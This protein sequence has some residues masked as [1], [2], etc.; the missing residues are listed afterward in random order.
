MIKHPLTVLLVDDN[1]EFI[2][3]MKCLLMELKQIEELKVAMDYEE[4]RKMLTSQTP[5]LV[6]LDIH[7][8]GKN[9]ID[10][11]KYIK[12]LDKPCRV[13]M[14]SNQADEYYRDLCLKEGADYFFDKTKDF[15]LIPDMIR[16]LNS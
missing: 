3:R 7:L 15:L 10:L 13:M 11:L 8:P 14:V 6:L 5:D 12:R 2:K 1:T 9:G 4:A 16:S